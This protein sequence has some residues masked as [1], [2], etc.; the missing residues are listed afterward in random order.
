MKHHASLFA[1]LLLLFACARVAPAGTETAVFGAGCF[2]CVEAFYEQ[3][4]GVTNVISGYAGGAEDNPTYKQVSAGTTGHAEVV[5][6]EFDP[7]LTSY[8]KLLDFF[9]TTHDP[10]NGGGVWPDFGKQYRSIILPS[11]EEQKAV[12]EK[13]KAAAEAKLRKPVA[14]EIA[15]LK[16]F[17][18]A[19]EY[20]QDYVRRNPKDPYVVGIALPKLKKHGLKVPGA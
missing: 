3:Q 7:A 9:W 4:P 11:G 6:V 16:K 1:S 20:H 12:A 19:E 10:T 14:T 8:E 13:S 18:A 5:Q 17:F 15:P 2:W